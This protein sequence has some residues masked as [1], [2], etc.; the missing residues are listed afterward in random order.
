[1]FLAKVNGSNSCHMEEIPLKIVSDKRLLHY[2]IVEDSTVF[3]MASH[4][5]FVNSTFKQDL[6]T[7]A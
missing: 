7:L 6:K 5:T 2:G 3:I 1:M 4:D